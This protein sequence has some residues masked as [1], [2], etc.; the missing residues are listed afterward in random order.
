MSISTDM[1]GRVA[2]V[3]GGTSGIGRAAALAFAGAG[4]TVIVTGRREAEGRETVELAERAG[5][6]ARF[7][8]A[9][10]ADGAQVAALFERIEREHGRLDAAFNNAGV[11]AM[12]P[13]AEM[14]E[15]DFDRILT[16]NVKG[17]WHCLRYELAIMRRQNGGA[18]VNTG[19]VLGQIGMAG[20]AAYSASKA[21]V[22]GLTRTAAIEA[23]KS[24]VRVNAVCPAIIQT[25]MSQGSFGG[26]DGVEAA[27][28][29]LH[30]VGR[31][32]R[33]EEVAA[34]VLWLCSDAAAFVT[35]Q[36]INIDGGVTA[37]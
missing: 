36:S 14:G 20:N 5:G 2:L 8:G 16:V 33:P 4:A 17:V 7:V 11:H 23:A 6:R 37:Q 10:V 34:A 19:S 28:G 24:G 30:P 3:T 15:A 1:S 12:A 27:L 13:I 25:P 32:G 9:D 22:E 31:V 29:P 21:A 26:A 35:G 18:I